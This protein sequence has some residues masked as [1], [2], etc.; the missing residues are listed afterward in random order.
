MPK[1]ALIVRGTWVIGLSNLFSSFRIYIAIKLFYKKEQLSF[2][3]V[4]IYLLKKQQVAQQAMV[5]HLSAINKDIK[6]FRI[7][8]K[9]SNSYLMLFGVGVSCSI[10]YSIVSYLYVSCNGSITSVGEES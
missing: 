2:C 8:L 10:L 6:I 3:I 1:C 7:V 4:R 9:L 5:A